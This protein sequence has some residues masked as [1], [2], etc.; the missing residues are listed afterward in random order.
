MNTNP[1]TP[2]PVQEPAGAVEAR[3]QALCPHCRNPDCNDWD[4][5]SCSNTAGFYHGD[6]REG[7]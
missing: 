2:H 1:T 7:Y 4:E 5:E 6:E 3:P